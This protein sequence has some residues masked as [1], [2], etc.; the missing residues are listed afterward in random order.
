MMMLGLVLGWVPELAAFS[1]TSMKDCRLAFL[2]GMGWGNRSAAFGSQE[3]DRAFER[4]A[5][6]CAKD[7]G[8]TD[9]ELQGDTWRDRVISALSLNTDPK[10]RIAGQM[11]DILG[12]AFGPE[13]WMRIDVVSAYAAGAYARHGTSAGFKMKNQAKGTYLVLVLQRLAGVSI[14]LAINPGMPGNL[15]ITLSGGGKDELADFFAEMRTIREV[16][17]KAR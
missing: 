4:V 2:L 12:E 15:I 7:L 14:N 6:A 11:N 13:V 8:A 16:I 1:P 17:E 5:R 3:H 10:K 9:A